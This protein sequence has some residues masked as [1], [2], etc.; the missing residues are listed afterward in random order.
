MAAV[1]KDMVSHYLKN[2]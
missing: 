2:K 1:S